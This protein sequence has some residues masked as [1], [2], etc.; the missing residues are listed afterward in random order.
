M[1]SNS[2]YAKKRDILSEK[3]DGASLRPKAVMLTHMRNQDFLNSIKTIPGH[4]IKQGK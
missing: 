3:R 1:F 4:R 2:K